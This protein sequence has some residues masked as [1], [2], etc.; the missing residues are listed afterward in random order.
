MFKLRT[1]VR[2]ADQQRDEYLGDNPALA[3]EWRMKP[4]LRDESRDTAIGAILRASSLDE[5]PQLWNVMRGEMSLIGPR[6]LL[7]ENLPFYGN[8]NAYF[9]LR[10]GLTGLWE[11]SGLNDTGL[12]ERATLD[13]LYYR[14]LSCRTDVLLLLRTFVAVT[15]RRS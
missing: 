1:M 10:P 4:A 15:S 11:M 3:D 6:P 8:P 14:N 5:L 2:G 13:A 9:A 12:A 7:P